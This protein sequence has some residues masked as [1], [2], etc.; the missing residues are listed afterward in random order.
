MRRLS[1]LFATTWIM[2]TVGVAQVQAQGHGHL[3]IHRGHHH[4]V[5][6][7]LHR[8]VH[9]VARHRHYVHPVVPVRGVHPP[10]VLS[11]VQNVAPVYFGPGHAGFTKRF[12][13]LVVKNQLPLNVRWDQGRYWIYHQQKWVVYDQF[14]R[15]HCH[16]NWNWYHSKYRAKYGF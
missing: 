8:R 5:V 7:H 11:R 12:H 14:V 6:H 1:I 9:H 4:R 2:A 15:V 16:G 13:T 10:V 3:R